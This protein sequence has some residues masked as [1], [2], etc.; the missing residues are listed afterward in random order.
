VT[1]DGKPLAEATV[2]FQH[3]SGTPEEAIFKAE[4]DSEG[5]YELAQFG[6]GARGARPGPYR[7]RITTVKL[8]P[9]ADERT[10]LPP[11]PVPPRYRDG[12]LGFEVPEEGTTEADFHITSG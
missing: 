8:P 2:V 9:D 12:S 1:L 5:K 4:T 3:L 10:P 11:E 6:S 7:V